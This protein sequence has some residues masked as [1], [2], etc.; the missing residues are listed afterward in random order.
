MKINLLPKKREIKKITY[1]TLHFLTLSA[2]VFN[3]TMVGV[4]ITPKAANATVTPPTPVANPVLTQSCGLDIGLLV[5]TSGSIDSGE[6]TKMKTALTSFANAFVGTPAVFSLSSFANESYL[7]RAFSRTPSQIAADISSDIPSDGNGWTNWDSGLARSFA[8]FDPRPAKPNLIVIATDGSPNTYGYFPDPTVE[9]THNPANADEL[10]AGLNHAIERANTIKTAGTRVV[11]LGIGDDESDPSTP[12]QKVD[13]MKQISGPNVAYTTADITTSTDVIKVENFDGIG[14]ALS[15]FVNQLC[16]GKILV[17]KQ[18]D[19]NGDGIAEI[20]GSSADAALAGYTFDVNG[21]PSN[22]T[23]QVTANTGSLS[24]DVLNGTYSVTET[25]LPANTEIVN[26]KC[27]NGTQ[28]VGTFSLATKTV[29]GLTMGTDDNISCTFLNKNVFGKL[30]V[31]KQVSGSTEPVSS[32]SMSV[33]KGGVNVAGSPQPGSTTGTEYNLEPGTYTVGETGPGGYAASFSASCPSGTATVTA[34]QTTTCTVTNTRQTGTLIVKK[35]VSGSTEPSASWSMHV[36]QGDQEVSGSP[37]AGT[38]A[39][40]SYTLPTGTYNISETGGPSNYTA[41]F[42]ADCVNGSATV[43]A[44]QT[45]TCTVTNTRDTGTIEL[46]KIWS[47]PAGQT[48]LNIGTTAGASNVDT[49]LTGAAG[50]PPL[51]TGQNT[52]NTGTYYVSETGG[53]SNYNAALVCTDNG[54]PITV[55]V[56]NSVNV[57][58]GHAVVCTFTNTRQT[59]TLIVKKV[60]SGSTEPSAS[61]SMHVKQS[62]QEVSGSP[63]AGTSTGTSYTLPTGTYNVSETGGPSNFTASFSAD[64]VNG[65]ATVTAGQTVTCTVTNTRDTGHITFNKIVSG[66]SAHDNDFTFSVYGQDYHDGDIATL[67]TGSYALTE[68]GPIGYTLSAAS[69]VCSFS[70]SADNNVTLTVTKDGGTC[71]ITN[72]RDT[73]TITVHKFLQLPGEDP[74]YDPENWSWTLSSQHGSVSGLAGGDTKTVLTIDEYTVAEDTSNFP[75]NNFATTWTCN[76]VGDENTPFANGTG[77]SFNFTL[78]HPGQNVVCTFTN[79]RETT[80]IT[81]DKVVVGGNEA[82]SAWAFAIDGQGAY[83]EGDVASLPTNEEFDITESSQFD[84]LYTLTGA[85][86]ICSL[87]DGHLILNTDFNEDSRILQSELPTCIVENTRNTGSLTAHKF[88]DAD[89][90]LETTGD[91]TPVAG[92][93]IELW[94]GDN[95]IDTQVTGEDGSYTWNILPTGNYV[96]K[97]IFDS[98]DYQ[99]LTATQFPAEVTTN[100][101]AEVTFSNFKKIDLTA[102]K[103]MDADGS[104]KTTQ[105]RSTVAGWTIELWQ[106]EN[107]LG[108]QTTNEEG[109]VVFENLGPGSYIVKEVFDSSKYTALTETEMQVTAVSG[110]DQTVSFVNF[111]NEPAI[112]LVKSITN[113]H[114]IPGGF[115]NYQLSYTNTGNLDLTNVKLVDDYPQQYQTITDPGTGIDNG[116]TLTWMI[117]NLAIGETGTVTYTTSIKSD[118]PGN[119]NIINLATI[120]SDQ[121]DPLTATATALVPLPPV[122]GQPVLTITK[123]VN[124]LF[125]NPGNHAIYTVTVANSGDAAAINAELSDLLPAGF[126]FTE[127]GTSTHTWALGDLAAGETKIITYE[128]TIGTGVTAGNYENLATVHADNHGSLQAKVNLEV[129]VPKVLAEEAEPLLTIE[130]TADKV[131]INQG[132]TVTYT[133]K[134][135]NQG[136]EDAEAVA[137]NVKTEDFLPAGFTFADGKVSKI[138]ELG[139]IRPGETRVITYTAKSDKT[140]LPGNYENL[141]SAWA[142]NH[143]KVTDSVKVEVR[144]IKVL[145]EALPTTGGSLMFYLYLLAIGLIIAFVGWVLKLTLSTSRE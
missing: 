67:P 24:F 98:A 10:A 57:T 11:V 93:T 32:W 42:S 59:G 21:S 62:D 7:R 34:G 121:T 22:P 109:F 51:T 63:A 3:M 132:D 50:A 114:L 48:T 142:D 111:T 105:D 73:G 99:A 100:E 53:L 33:K 29:S 66:G 31:I 39:G 44:G 107:L 19:T 61:W 101:N 140:L 136:D 117:G 60:V 74:I 128:V 131:F 95:K 54:S 38:S 27:V 55:G 108:S 145:G 5:D 43:T 71:N 14:A 36:K 41:S 64:C 115:I 103:L 91:Q 69:G 137:L 82:D 134:V 8:T 70:P 17:Q 127:F 12:A 141:A 85:S 25:N 26:G 143:D 84:N 77:T 96:V 49:Q 81:F 126:T 37:A 122:E 123:A 139:D 80:E 30:K 112:T 20:T 83:H 144:K 13:K 58:K 104:A 6:M 68:S 52:V 78:T 1:K 90:N 138:W 118:V 119:T 4:F 23:P 16:G 56:N 106:G 124:K 45:V 94:Q 120:T 72:T 110:Q 102:S 92:W 28:N 65:T 86:G 15:E 18:F 125:V 130:K 89:G 46:K 2:L 9:P 116:D 129:R 40:T 88:M 35:V 87:E 79:V 135:T 76:A 47:G 75:E 113:S 133:I 97:E